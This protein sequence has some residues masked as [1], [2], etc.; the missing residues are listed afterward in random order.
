LA[1]LLEAHAIPKSVLFVPEIPLLATGKP[2]RQL[3][4]R[5]LAATDA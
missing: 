1:G 5:L 4:Q 2:D 3:L